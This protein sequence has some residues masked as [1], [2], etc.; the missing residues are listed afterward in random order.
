VIDRSEHRVQLRR[1][2]AANPVVALV[3]A[4]QVGKTTLARA[5][6]KEVDSGAWFDCE[7]PADLARLDSP[8]LALGDLRGLVV[9]DEVQRRPELFTILRVLADRRPI[10]TR[11]L[12]LGSAS[13]DLLKQ[14][15][16]TLAG[17]I[18]YYEL[19]GLV[20][21]EVGPTRSAQLWL[22]G[23]FP[24]SFTARTGDQS[25]QWRRDFVRT[26][27]ERDV[28]Q[29]GS[30]VPA[31]TLR[32]FWSMLAHVHGQVLNW[33]ELGRS[34]GVTDHVVRNYAEL[35]EGTFMLRLLKPW[36]ANIS[37]RQ[38]KAPKAYIRDSG[39][40]HTLLDIRRRDELER[41]PKVGASWEGFCIEAVAY[42]LR[43]EPD[44]CFFWATH[45]GAELDLLVVQ[46]GRMRGFEVKY[47]DAPQVTPSMRSAVADLG[48]D[49]LDV[50]HAGSQ[51]YDMAARI[52][53]VPMERIWQEVK[54]SIG[55]GR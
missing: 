21:D 52:R 19:G 30:R 27:L 37:K 31:P 38:V 10:K 24:P 42:Q 18:A 26:F 29:L 22:R 20:A 44:E 35:L 55:R 28:P 51:T 3:G 39:L 49:S 32:R 48:L 13:P 41:H 36:H 33:S 9:I 53:A 11:F 34:M 7:D 15:S 2:L 25:A 47:T 50:I 17:R 16:E 1:L 8:R 12:V 45:G 54:P 5:L 14:S 23:G 4:R 46:G 43:A 40:L 6:A